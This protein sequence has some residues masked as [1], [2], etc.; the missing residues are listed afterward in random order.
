M[1]GMS[2]VMCC[3]QGAVAYL[4]TVP[5]AA[6]NCV[7]VAKPLETAPS[8]Q[9]GKGNPLLERQLRYSVVRHPP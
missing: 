3:V 1:G 5:C 7:H 8:M 9:S 2:Q 6:P 4:N